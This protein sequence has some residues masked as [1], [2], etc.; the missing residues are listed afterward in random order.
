M[1][2]R[3]HRHHPPCHAA[4]AARCTSDCY[5]CRRIRQSLELC[6]RC[7]NPIAVV[8]WRLLAGVLTFRRRRSLGDRR[9]RLTRSRGGGDGAR[10]LVRAQTSEGLRGFFRLPQASAG[11]V[12]ARTSEEVDNGP[13]RLSLRRRLSR[14]L[15]RHRWRLVATLRRTAWR[16]VI[17]CGHDGCGRDGRSG[18]RGGGS[19]SCGVAS[20]RC[21]VQHGCSGGGSG[22]G[23]SR[24]GCRRSRRRCGTRRRRAAAGGDSRGKGDGACSCGGSYR[25]WGRREWRRS[26]GR[27]RLRPGSGARWRCGGGQQGRRALRWLHRVWQHRMRRRISGWRH[28]RRARSTSTCGRLLRCCPASYL[29]S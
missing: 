2:C 12:R 6:R 25:K 5:R 1:L 26:G 17:R 23:G 20:T 10:G 19:G 28:R 7:T 27:L 18:S 15:P 29:R 13:S 3:L 14:E 21:S 9:C 11:L 24:G 16:L 4:A 8:L 22:G